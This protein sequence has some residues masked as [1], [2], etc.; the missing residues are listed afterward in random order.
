MVIQ[1]SGRSSGERL[2]RLQQSQRRRRQRRQR[3][4][5]AAILILNDDKVQRARY[6]T[7]TERAKERMVWEERVASL[8]AKQ[9]RRRYRMTHEA[10]DYVL[11][12]IE[13][14][15][16]KQRANVPDQIPNELLL[17]MALRWA[18]GGSFLDIAD[19]HG[20]SEKRFY[21]LLWITMQAIVDGLPALELMERLDK[22]AEGALAPLAAEFDRKSGNLFTGCIGAVDGI[23]IKIQKPDVHGAAFF[24]YKGVGS[25]TAANY[26]DLPMCWVAG[27]FSL[28]MQCVADSDRRFIWGSVL[29][30]GSTHD[31]VALELSDLGKTLTDPEHP[32]QS[33][34]YFI[35]GDDAYKGVG[36]RSRSLLCP[37]PGKAVG[38]WKDAFN[39]YQS[40]CRIEVE[41]AFG[42]LVKKWGVLHRKL[43][44]SVPHSILLLEALLKLHN[45]CID[46]RVPEERAYGLRRGRA[47]VEDGDAD[48]S[49]WEH[50]DW[51]VPT[52][53][54]D[55]PPRAQ[56]RQTTARRAAQ[57][58]LRT[59]LTAKLRA[60]PSCKGRPK[61]T[62]YTGYVRP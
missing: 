44:C 42:S 37:W 14:H 31:V 29:T 39:A 21:P 50:P 58:P 46:M 18:A 27:F 28:N 7:K 35:A 36:N 20:V 26:S 48:L 38:K 43:T 16:P 23:H 11:E 17:S 51:R 3:E 24:C 55:P 56:G 53:F 47:G 62:K 49:G 30:C 13:P 41:C 57:Q 40:I 61:H 2:Q 32:I 6:T 34:E 1:Q 52:K 60:S 8:T 22:V 15:L 10:F 54:L 4:Q 33:T 59:M 12:Q 25:T 5:A 19:M 45:M 9:F